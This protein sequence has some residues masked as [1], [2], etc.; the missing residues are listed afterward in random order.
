MGDVKAS[1]PLRAP[2]QDHEVRTEI[3][4]FEPGADPTVEQNQALMR[5]QFEKA[6]ARGPVAMVLT[7]EFAGGAATACVGP[8]VTL[9]TL[10]RL[11]LSQTLN[12]LGR[13]KAAGENG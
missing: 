8:P 7:I 11:G 10:A 12:M 9:E 6:M 2:Q 13:A 4:R 3:T 1:A 5:E